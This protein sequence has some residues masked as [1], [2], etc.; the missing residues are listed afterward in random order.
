MKKLNKGFTM[1][2]LLIV[3]A[4]IGVLSATATPKL[5]KEL[6]KG[7]VAKIQ[8]NLGVIRSKLSL[9]E[10]L[11]DEFPD[12]ANEEEGDVTDLL[13]SYSIE[14]TL[15]FTD[16]DGV[17]YSE[18]DQVVDTRDNTGGWLYDR[19]EG[20]I[21]AN[22]PDGAYTYDEE[23]EI[24]DEDGSE[25]VVYDF[26]DIDDF[27]VGAASN[28]DGWSAATQNGYQSALT[29]NTYD[30]Y[31]I[32]TTVTFTGTNSG[33]G[34]YIQANEDSSGYILQYDY[35]LGKLIIK[36]RAINDSG[37]VKETGGSTNTTLSTIDK[38]SSWWTD[39]HD[40][41]INVTND[42]ENTQNV[43]IIIDDE[44]ITSDYK[45]PTSDA[46]NYTGIRSWTNDSNALTT[47]DV[48]S[49]SITEL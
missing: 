28:I 44:I 35:Q 9:D 11:L 16:S 21:Y 4:I 1:I 15:A 43:E 42:D 27:S 26:T 25:Y 36:P 34:I 5:M 46:D 31:S 48:D 7:K 41:T 14:P 47:V 12:L 18:T 45:I 2:E 22:L 38:T 6:R 19:E 29:L 8:H 30:E 33:Y 13:I 10:T 49:V 20:V 39:E 3:I 37:S 17:S 24:W 23:Y 40:I 32:E